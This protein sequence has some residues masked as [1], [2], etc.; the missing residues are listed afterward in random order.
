MQW[1]TPQFH[2]KSLANLQAAVQRT[3]KLCAVIVDTQGRECVANSQPRLDAASTPIYD[4]KLSVQP[5]DKVPLPCQLARAKGKG[6]VLCPEIIHAPS[7]P[8]L[9]PRIALACPLLE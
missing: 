2:A 3:G 5:K 6:V 1:G 8:T 7:P 9:P 4:R